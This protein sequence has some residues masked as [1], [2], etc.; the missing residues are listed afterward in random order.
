MSVAD[1]YRKHNQVEEGASIDVPNEIQDE[2]TPEDVVLVDTP[3]E[4]DEP[5]H[6]PPAD[7]TDEELA[8]GPG[9]PEPEDSDLTQESLTVPGSDE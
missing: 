8:T 5:P 4:E 7:S 3:V 2:E 6:D 9:N 1:Q